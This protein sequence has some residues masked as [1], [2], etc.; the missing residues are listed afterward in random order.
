M[1]QVGNILCFKVAPL[2]QANVRQRLDIWQTP[3]VDGI[4]AQSLGDGEGQFAFECMTMGTPSYVQAWYEALAELAGEFVIIIDDFVTVHTP[5]LI[6]DPGQLQRIA[7]V[8]ND[9]LGTCIGRTVVSG[10]YQ[11]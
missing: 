9:G 5:C 7:R 11:A 4:G 8:N 10:A 6:V 2:V 3:G 1:P